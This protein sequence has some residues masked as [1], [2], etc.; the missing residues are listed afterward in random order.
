MRLKAL[1]FGLAL[2]ALAVSQASAQK[3]DLGVEAGAN[4][5]NFIGSSVGSSS[6]TGSRL[7]MVGGAF[8]SL[9]FGDSFAIRPEIL[10]AQKGA[11]DTSNNTYQLDYLEVPVLVK[12]S[13]GTPVFNP[14]IL[15]GPSF[16][17]NTVANVVSS[18]GNSQAIQNVDTSDV[19]F[20]GG[21]EIDISKFFVTGRYEVGFN[22]IVNAANGGSQSNIQNGTIT[23]MIGY[24][25]L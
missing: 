5:A 12:L 11:K 21:V 19:G 25:F 6:L 24:S 7:G 3:F 8:L 15:V 18:G 17:W 16:N 23:A 22:N 9:N 1:M 4:F 20:I 10:Y 2:A 14:G 13:L